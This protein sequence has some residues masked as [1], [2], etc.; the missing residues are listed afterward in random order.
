ME[1]HIVRAADG[2]VAGPRGALRSN[3]P[4]W[5]HA[6]HP[7]GGL[8]ILLMGEHMPAMM[9]ALSALRNTQP[10]ETGARNADRHKTRARWDAKGRLH[11]FA[12]QPG[13]F[14]DHATGDQCPLYDGMIVDEAT[15]RAFS[16][17]ASI[18]LRGIWHGRLLTQGKADSVFSQRTAKDWADRHAGKLATDLQWSISP[19][20]FAE[21][22][23][24]AFR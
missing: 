6:D 9:A 21:T 15:C 13:L 1:I 16:F 23:C 20:R 17:Q 19:Q 2:F 24:D 7:H 5:L 3:S 14:H 8:S 4:Y 18:A 10:D 11:L 22:V 12:D